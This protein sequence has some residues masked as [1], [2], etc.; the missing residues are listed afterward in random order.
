M[1]LQL[2]FV[3]QIDRDS[4]VRCPHCQHEGPLMQDFSLLASGFNGIKSG[5]DDCDKQECGHCNQRSA[6]DNIPEEES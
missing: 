4:I 6:W 3:R 2:I 5:E 1:N